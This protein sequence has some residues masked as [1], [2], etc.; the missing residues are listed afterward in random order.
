M[1][2]SM[3]KNYLCFQIQSIFF[4]LKW[5]YS[6]STW[7]TLSSL[8][9][10]R[11]HDPTLFYFSILNFLFYLWNNLILLCMWL[12]W[13]LFKYC[14]VI[15]SIAMVNSLFRA[16]ADTPWS[17]CAGDCLFLQISATWH[18]AGTEYLD[19]YLS[20][21][22]TIVLQRSIQCSL[23]KNWGSRRNYLKT[24]KWLLSINS[25]FKC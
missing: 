7:P 4:Q 23:Y 18:K 1:F 22:T 19:R 12:P 16:E 13:R 21:Q 20:L 14:K 2:S 17:P 8:I 24:N 6:V 9:N 5:I 25:I 11:L 15:S 3:R 10:K